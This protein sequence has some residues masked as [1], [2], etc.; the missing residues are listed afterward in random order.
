MKYSFKGICDI[1]TDVMPEETVFSWLQLC[2]V[3]P[4]LTQIPGPWMLMEQNF[5]IQ[6]LVEADTKA[7]KEFLE[8]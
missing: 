7:F 1:W 4:C 2:S 3:G 6:T 8:K 5:N